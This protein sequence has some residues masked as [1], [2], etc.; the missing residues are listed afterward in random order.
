V[1]YFLLEDRL[2]TEGS[3]AKTEPK[4]PVAHLTDVVVS[5]LSIPK[6]WGLM[7]A[8]DGKLV[9]MIEA[10]KLE[11]LLDR[12]FIAALMRRATRV[13]GIAHLVPPNN[14]WAKKAAA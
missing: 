11:P 10:P 5:R 4:M 3:R 2:N 6:G 14:D 9:T 1:I 13:D 12:A 8:E 7:F